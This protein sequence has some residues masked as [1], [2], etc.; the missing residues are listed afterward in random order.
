MKTQRY[1]LTFAGSTFQL[2]RLDAEQISSIRQLVQAV[3]FHPAGTPVTERDR[4]V[5]LDGTAGPVL[6]I[7]RQALFAR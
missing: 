6:R 1:T 4:W 7:D 3:S 2:E 5:S